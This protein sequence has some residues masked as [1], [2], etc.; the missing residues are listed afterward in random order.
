VL[1]AGSYNWSFG[2]LGFFV[3]EM[4]KVERG[5][6]NHVQLPWKVQWSGPMDNYR[7]VYKAFMKPAF[8]LRIARQALLALFHWIAQDPY[9]LH[10]YLVVILYSVWLGR[11]GS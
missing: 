10:N 1:L 5:L 3:W 2:K 11:R 6:G 4:T 8:T 9:D 7:Y